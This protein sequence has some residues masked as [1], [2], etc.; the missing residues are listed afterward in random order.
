MKNLYRRYKISQLLDEPL[1][2]EEKEIIDFIIDKIKDVTLFIDDNGCH[3][4]MNS[5]GEFIFKYNEEDGRMLVRYNGFWKVLMEKYSLDGYDVRDI[6]KGVVETTYKIKVGK[7]ISS[8][9]ISNYV[10]ES[11]YKI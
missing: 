6:I 11:L 10:I 2:N 3:N 9:L 4:Y 7:V 5:I 8:P 1:V